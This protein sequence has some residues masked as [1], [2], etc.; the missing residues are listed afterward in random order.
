LGQVLD[1]GEQRSG[2][3]G[4][5]LYA[6]VV[7]RVRVLRRLLVIALLVTSGSVVGAC[8][9]AGEAPMPT[10]A[11]AGDAQLVEGRAIYIARCQRCHGPKGG[12]GAGS[13]LAGRLVT[14][15]PDP[16]AQADIIANGKGGMP[17]W[18][19]VLSPEQIDAVVR[20]TREV[21]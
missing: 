5:G 14:R 18:R 12:G 13:A 1:M 8:A 6:A 3:P 20:Y 7:Q 15:Y 9:Q 16:A 19:N 2:E 21:L 10:G 4:S 17:A 11:A